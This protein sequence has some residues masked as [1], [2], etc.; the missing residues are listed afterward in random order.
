MTDP[1]AGPRVFAEAFVDLPVGLNADPAGPQDVLAAVD[2]MGDVEFAGCGRRDATEVEVAEEMGGPDSRWAE[3]VCMVRRGPEAVAVVI[4]YDGLAEDRG[5]DV[6][7]YVRPGD[8]QRADII[9]AAVDAGLLEGRARWALVADPA[10]KAPIA[11]SFAFAND[12]VSRSELTA[13]GFAEARRYWRMRIDHG[14]R[15][16]PDAAGPAALPR[17]YALRTAVLDRDAPRIHAVSNAAFADHFDSTP[18]PFSR[19]LEF[20]TGATSDPAQWTVAEHEGLIVGFA[21]G[22]NRLA[23]EGAGYVTSLAVL[24]EHRGR[25]LAAALLET[26]FADD[27][28]RGMGSTVLHCDAQNTTGATRLYQR[29]GM[30]VDQEMVAYHRPLAPTAAD[31][32][33]VSQSLDAIDEDS[34]GS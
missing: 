30:R 3:G 14:E 17:G 33:A 21:L 19:W 24:K 29:V 16:T 22:S 15:S 9:G 8:P 10:L 5:W 27:V 32:H 18:L 23:A 25:G 2:V 7:V 31:G 26:R 1:G 13:R 11:R 12:E 20:M 6:D 28:R 4:T 34:A